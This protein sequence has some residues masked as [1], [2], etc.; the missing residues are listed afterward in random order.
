MLPADS[1]SIAENRFSQNG[2]N[3]IHWSQGLMTFW[4]VSDIAVTELDQFKDLY[5]KLNR[6][7]TGWGRHVSSFLAQESVSPIILF[8]GFSFQVFRS[9]FDIPD[10][11]EY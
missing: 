6:S 10:G 8:T 5:E 9:P 7:R 2:Y 11:S 1:A 3:A 4:A